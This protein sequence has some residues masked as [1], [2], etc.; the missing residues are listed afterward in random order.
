MAYISFAGIYLPRLCQGH[1]KISK[2]L[3]NG[4]CFCKIG[5]DTYSDIER[6]VF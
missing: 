1:L 2:N 6:F 3:T 4:L 5:T